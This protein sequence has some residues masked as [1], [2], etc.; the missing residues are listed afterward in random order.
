MQPSGSVQ[1]G[2]LSV[3]L[4]DTAVTSTMKPNSHFKENR[5]RSALLCFIKLCPA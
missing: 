3:Q 4:V 2:M 5:K 1:A